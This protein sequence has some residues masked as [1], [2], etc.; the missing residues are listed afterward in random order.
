MED[1][2]YELSNE[3]IAIAVSNHGAEL[4]SVQKDGKEYLWQAGVP[5]LWKRRFCF[6]LSAALRME[7]TSFMA[8]NIP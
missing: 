6:R 2:L 1:R 3:E 5:G 8:E 7:N 4:H